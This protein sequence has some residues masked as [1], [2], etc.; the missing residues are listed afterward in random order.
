MFLASGFDGFISKPIDLRRLNA[1]LNRL[2]RDKQTPETLD[3]VR[4]QFASP[5]DDDALDPVE[6]DAESDAG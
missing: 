6:D 5:T 4:R 2:I 3:A 1:V